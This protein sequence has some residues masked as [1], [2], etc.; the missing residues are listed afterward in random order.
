MKTV[1]TSNLIYVG[2]NIFCANIN[3]HDGRTFQ[4]GND[5]VHQH[6][7][8]KARIPVTNV[9]A[10]S[11][12]DIPIG[13]VGSWLKFQRGYIALTRQ[14]IIEGGNSLLGIYPPAAEMYV[15][16]HSNVNDGN[17]HAVLREGCI[18]V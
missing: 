12:M 7:N 5:S 8:S 14:W 9:T 13:H 16:F 6:L 1:N 15:A 4:K 3:D 10:Y 17:T 18:Q 11:I 2:R